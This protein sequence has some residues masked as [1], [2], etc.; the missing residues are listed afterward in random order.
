MKAMDENQ[1]VLHANLQNPTRKDLA[2]KLDDLIKQY[3]PAFEGVYKAI[4]ERNAIITGE[5]DASES[6]NAFSV[7]SA[8]VARLG[9]G[10]KSQIEDFMA[11]AWLRSCGLEAPSP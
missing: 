9:R 5:L 7:R 8:M 4:T 1:N 3:G 10:S 2:A 6:S 11:K